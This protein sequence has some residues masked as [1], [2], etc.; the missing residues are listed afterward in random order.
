MRARTFIFIL[1]AVVTLSLLVWRWY[2]TPSSDTAS[3]EASPVIRGAVVRTVEVTGRVE[4]LERVTL[5]FP[6]G[7]RIARM[8]VEEGESVTRGQI[9]AELVMDDHEASVREA[10]ARLRFE[11]ARYTES[12][13]PVREETR[14]AEEVAVLQAERA[15][16]TAE[17]NARVAIERVYAQADDAVFKKASILFSRSTSN[18]SFGV[19]FEYQG[20]TYF[21]TTS[22]QIRAEINTLRAD[23]GEALARMRDRTMDTG[24]D[25]AYVLE[26]TKKD[27]TFIETF[28]T[29]L[30]EVVNAYIPGNETEQT[31]YETYRTNVS[32]GRSVI[33][34]AQSDIASIASALSVAQ[35]AYERSLV[36]REARIAGPRLETVRTQEASVEVARRALES[37]RTYVTDSVITAPIQGVVSIV[38]GKEGEVVTPSVPVIEILT[39]DSYEIEAYIPEADIADIRLGQRARITFDAFAKDDLFLGEVIRIALSETIRDGVPAYKTTFVI[40]EFPREDI[41]LRPGMTADCEIAISERTDVLYVP[42]RSIQRVGERAFVRVVEQAGILERTIVEGLRGSAGT[43]EVLSGLHEGEKVVVYVKEE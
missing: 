22:N 17:E 5:A 39:P 29:K 24:T 33:T 11:E 28:F 1:L 35:S 18:P 2:A 4:P 30:A 16:K 37:A 3:Y 12:V 8:L 20:S 27:L 9:L 10:E 42:T 13:L 38:H 32:Q 21:I 41:V 26:D 25:I 36:D 6:S 15:L 7:G 43:T 19:Q 23:T 34:T 40:S 14:T 31:V